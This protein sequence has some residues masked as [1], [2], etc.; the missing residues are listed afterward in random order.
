MTAGPTIRPRRGDL[1]A[2]THPHAFRPSG[3]LVGR[4]KA[5]VCDLCGLAQRGT[6]IHPEGKRAD[7]IS[8]AGYEFTG[9][10]DYLGNWIA[11]VEPLTLKAGETL[12]AVRVDGEWIVTL[13][14]YGRP[15][16]VTVGPDS[17]RIRSL[18]QWG[19]R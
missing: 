13:A 16:P 2:A 19:E 7:S 5:E 1:E 3:E 18:F 9:F 8:G 11:P 6:R 10:S 12:N 17:E 15:I 14:P 4:P